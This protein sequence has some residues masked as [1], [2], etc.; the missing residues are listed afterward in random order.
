MAIATPPS[1]RTGA[2]PAPATRGWRGRSAVSVLDHLDECLESLDDAHVRAAAQDCVAPRLVLEPGPWRP[3]SDP[4]RCRA[5]M[6]M[7]VVE[8]LLTRAVDVDGHRAQE[9][10]GPGDLLRPWDDEG[11]SATVPSV[12][13]WR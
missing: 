3:P 12:T 11:F 8:G 5:W 2:A 1:T 7:L 4:R 13:S 9:L 10:L 6:G